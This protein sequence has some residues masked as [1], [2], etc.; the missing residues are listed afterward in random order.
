MGEGDPS[1]HL[2]C[3]QHFLSRTGLIPEVQLQPLEYVPLPG[4][5]SA[6]SALSAEGIQVQPCGSLA[7]NYDGFASRV[8][9]VAGSLWH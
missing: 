7:L 5:S 2:F 3:Q 6:L 4:G 9:I 1:N 8:F